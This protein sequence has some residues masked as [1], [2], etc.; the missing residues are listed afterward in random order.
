MVQY[1]VVNTIQDLPQFSPDYP[2]FCDIESDGLY[3]NVRLIQYYQPETSP[4]IFILDVDYFG[5]HTRGNQANALFKALGRTHE[6]KVTIDM[7]NEFHS[8]KWIVWWNGSYDQGTLRF[9]SAKVDDLWYMA[10]LALP[11]LDAFNLDV[12]TNHLF[13]QERFYEGIAKKEMH[14]KGQ[15]RPGPL[16]EQHLRYAATDVYVMKLI[17][18]KIAD[19][20]KDTFVYKLDALNQ[21]YCV[22]WQ[23]TGLAVN[24]ELRKLA[25]QEY[26]E[27]LIKAIAKLPAGLNV[28]SFKQV[29]ACLTEY[30]G[31]PIEESDED[32]LL[33]L[34]ADG[35]PYSKGI[36][37]ERGILKTLNFLE[38][39]DRPK[40]YANYNPF[41][42]R[43]GR[44]S[45]KGGD[46][47]DAANLQQLPR[48]LKKVFGYSSNS[49]MVLVGAD[50][51]TAELR[52][53]AAIYV[54]DR[55]VYAFKNDI[56]LHRLTA[57]NTLGCKIEEVS[58]EDR[59]KAKAENFGLLYGMKA[60]KFQQYAFSNY[61]IILTLEEAE[62][63]RTNWMKV[64]PGIASKI[65]EVTK[66]FFD[67]KQDPHKEALLVATP[68]GRWVKPEL[69]TDA[70]NIPIQGAVAEI[71]KLWIHYLQKLH[72]GIPPIANFVHDSIT[73]ECKGIEAEYWK[74]KLE[75]S[76]AMAWA[77]Y[78]KLPMIRVK[79]IPMPIEV[80]IS[81]SYQGAS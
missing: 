59:K 9:T 12:V 3:V 68:L 13:P 8:D 5:N 55:M 22:Q 70:L 42:T 71:S 26:R 57:S 75:E 11:R 14:Q 61:G 19:M 25:E 37:E 50:L 80:G 20:V 74:Q 63:R 44:W 18:D 72:G 38:T 2:L 16:N 78:C 58:D 48:K 21:Q 76:C 46:R 41:G 66:R 49:D 52:L 10:K 47:E 64:Y 28:N 73:L 45:C 77:E 51:P 31:R 23:Q 56:D 24:Y 43:T 60:N 65:Q 79:D 6:A 81:K 35:C 39:Y 54:D 4:I 34:A 27:E 15:W 32:A 29:R 36:L 33:R 1:K 69:Y 30:H 17:W 53:A 67:H 40:V 7:V 62:Q